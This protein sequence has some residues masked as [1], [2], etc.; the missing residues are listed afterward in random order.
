MA[1]KWSQSASRVLAILEK[2]AAY[3]PV[4]IT[5]LARLVDADKSAVQR[6]LMTLA[7]DGWIRV[8][9]GKARRWE[10][11]ERIQALAHLALG[12]HDLRHRARPVL[13]ALRD[14]TGESVL[15]NVPNSEKA[16]SSKMRMK[17]HS[18]VPIF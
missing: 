11:T 18:S 1:V 14:K 2:I 12:S 5:E 6:A 3:Q 15:L 9:P 13:Q 8:A 16:P 4:G 10:V 7:R 17:W